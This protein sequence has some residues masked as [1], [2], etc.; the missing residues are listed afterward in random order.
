M[1]NGTMCATQRTMCCV[2]ENYQ[3][4]EGLRVPEVLQPYMGGVDFIPYPK[5][6]V[7]AFFKKK[8]EEKKAEATAAKKGKGGGKQKPAEK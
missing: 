2:L 1:L 4:P 5:K 7:E 3:T 8:E 6:A